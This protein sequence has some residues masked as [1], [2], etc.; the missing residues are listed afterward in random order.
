MGEFIKEY[1][2]D[3]RNEL[4]LMRKAERAAYRCPVEPDNSPVLASKV[5]EFT[6]FCETIDEV[7]T[8]IETYLADG[9]SALLTPEKRRDVFSE[10]VEWFLLKNQCDDHPSPY[11][12]WAWELLLAKRAGD[13]DKINIDA[14]RGHQT[15]SGHLRFEDDPIPIHYFEKRWTFAYLKRSCSIKHSIYKIEKTTGIVLANHGRARGE[16]GHGETLFYVEFPSEHIGLHATAKKRAGPNGWTR[17]FEI[18]KA[19][20][21]DAIEKQ[22]AGEV[23][24]RYFD[25]Y[26]DFLDFLAIGWSRTSGTHSG[27]IGKVV[28]V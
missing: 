22:K 19:S 9:S 28:F 2:E 17:I 23:V 16:V 24:S 4:E 20:L 5:I 26:E 25:S 6:H 18:P 11:G 14:M 1:T 3:W 27:L 15:L 8:W 13:L 10:F 12:L 21:H 7:H